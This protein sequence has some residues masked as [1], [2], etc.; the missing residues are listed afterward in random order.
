[1]QI[2]APSQPPLSESPCRR[3]RAAFAL[4]SSTR[5][6]C[7]IQVDAAVPIEIASSHAPFYSKVT[8]GAIA[9][10]GPGAQSASG[11]VSII[12]LLHPEPDPR[13]R[14]IMR[15]DIGGVQTLGIAPSGAAP[16]REKVTPAAT[17]LLMHL[18]PGKNG[19]NDTTIKA[20][21]GRTERRMQQSTHW[22]GDICSGWP[23]FGLH[24][25]SLRSQLPVVVVNS[26]SSLVSSIK[27][28]RQDVH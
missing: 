17:P 18:R 11:A 24:I 7:A 23:K 5:R 2:G 10:N 28:T 9:K 20:T 19:G 14:L 4:S 22:N 21:R 8:P 1:M 15:G 12:Q 3:R 25:C 6:G 13:I 26:N 27:N 16:C